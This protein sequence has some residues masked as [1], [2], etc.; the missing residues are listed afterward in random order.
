MRRLT[1]AVPYSPA[2]TTQP[3]KNSAT[4][5]CDDSTAHASPAARNPL[6]S[7]WLAASTRVSSAF[8]GVLRNTFSPA[9]SVHRN[10]SSP[11]KYRRSKATSSLRVRER[12]DRDRQRVV[13][14]K[15]GSGGGDLGGRGI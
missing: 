13:W 8:S 5:R 12:I 1:V 11:R 4:S 2:T 9:G 3:R 6:Y 15:S 10:I 14:R 7:P